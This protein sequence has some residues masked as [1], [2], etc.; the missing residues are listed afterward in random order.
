[1]ESK[2]SLFSLNF[3][4]IKVFLSSLELNLTQNVVYFV[5]SLCLFTHITSVIMGGGVGN[6]QYE[7]GGRTNLTLA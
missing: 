4:T 7:E 1:M 5:F 3:M 6:D 2:V